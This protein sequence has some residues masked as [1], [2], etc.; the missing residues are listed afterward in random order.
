LQDTLFE[1]LLTVYIVIGL[2]TYQINNNNNYVVLVSNS[3]GVGSRYTY[4]NGRYILLVRHN[5]NSW[6]CTTI[7]FVGSYSELD[8]FYS[9]YIMCDLPKIITIDQ[10]FC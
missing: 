1:H 10:R 3:N 6:T 2:V 4:F 7:D 5:N 8:V 9:E